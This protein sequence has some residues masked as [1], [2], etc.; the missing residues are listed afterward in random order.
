MDKVEKRRHA[1]ARRA[2]RRKGIKFGALSV[3][4]VHQE[5]KM[6]EPTTPFTKDAGSSRKKYVKKDSTYD[7]KEKQGAEES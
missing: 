4:V 2:V 7:R 3:E 1:A 5:E 6:P